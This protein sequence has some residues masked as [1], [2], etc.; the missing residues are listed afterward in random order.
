[1]KSPTTTTSV[2]TR[3]KGGGFTL[4]PREPSLPPPDAK[5]ISGKQLRARFGNKSAMWLWRRTRE[6]KDFPQPAYDGRLQIFN[7]TEIEAYESL[8]IQRRVGAEPRTM[9][10]RL[11]KARA[12][13]QGQATA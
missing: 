9:P 2:T 3:R 11:K 7:V 10:N 13:A 12:K 6:D 1:M 4:P 8:L 5:W